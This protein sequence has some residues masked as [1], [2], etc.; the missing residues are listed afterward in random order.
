MMNEKE[1]EAAGAEEYALWRSTKDRVNSIKE[2]MVANATTHLNR[3]DKVMGAAKAGDMEPMT[4]MM[5]DSVGGGIAGVVKGT[6]RAL[7]R[8]ASAYN[9]RFS[10]LYTLGTRVP[11]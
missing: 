11:N 5:L 3:L 8:G 1:I 6:A 10:F 2:Y 7:K 4:N 9:R